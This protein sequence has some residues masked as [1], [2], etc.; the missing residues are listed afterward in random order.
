MSVVISFYLSFQD[1][2]SNRLVNNASC[3]HYCFGVCVLFNIISMRQKE[4]QFIAIIVT[5]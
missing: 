1:I 4:L 5:S 3:Y 2:I